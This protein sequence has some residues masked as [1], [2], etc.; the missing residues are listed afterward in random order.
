[1]N[2]LKYLQ[3]IK[4]L[5]RLNPHVI[6][7][8]GDDAAVVTFDGP[9]QWLIT[10]DMLVE[11]VHFTGEATPPELIG[12][13]LMA[14]NLSDIA[15]MAG[16]PA[17]ATVSLAIP[18][19]TSDTYVY[20]LS[21]GIEDLAHKFGVAIVGGDTNGTSGPLTLSMTLLGRATAKGPVMRSTA[22]KGDAILVTGRLGGSRAGKHL[23]FTP[24][25]E[26]ALYL[27][28]HYSLTSLIDVSDG[29]ASDLRRLTEDRGL[30]AALLKAKIPLAEALGQ[31]SDKL[32]HALT[33][34]EDFELLFTLDPLEA[35]ALLHEQALVDCPL[36]RIGTVIETPGLFWLAK[37]QYLEA[38]SWKGYV[39][40]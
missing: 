32:R 22:Q 26:E 39:H 25:V 16:V 38:I 27:H 34:G 7:G 13:K 35:E 4:N 40:G 11:G 28:Q 20:Q 10:S 1:M 3:K 17:I 24:R 14:V 36:T 21:K 9:L 31:G 23:H 18:R 37:D 6:V 2:E 30:G 33:D 15:A 12:R 29:L 8:P 5:H 19:G